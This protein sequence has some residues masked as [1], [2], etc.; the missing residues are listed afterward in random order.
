VLYFASDGN[1]T[2]DGV[3]GQFQNLN[4]G[5]MNNDGNGNSGAV[6]G[7]NLNG[8]QGIVVAPDGRF[9]VADTGNNRILVVECPTW[10]G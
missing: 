1:T 6:S 2:A 4:T 5:V 3:Y 7:D 9:Y 10:P 8:S